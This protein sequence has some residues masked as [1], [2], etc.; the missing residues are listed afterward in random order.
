VEDLLARYTKPIRESRAV[1]LFLRRYPVYQALIQQGKCGIFL[2]M[3]LKS[4][5]FQEVVLKV[6]YHRGQVQPDGTDGCSLLRRELAFYRELDARN[7][8]SLAPRLVDALD[9]PRK[10]ILVLEY[11][12]GKNLLLRKLQGQLTVEHVERC[13]AIMDSL[14]ACGAYLGDAKLA[15]FMMTNDGD[16]RVLD[17]EAAGIF[18][19]ES[20]AFRTFFVNPEP[21]NPYLA[22]RAHFLASVLDSYEEGHFRWED[23]C[24][25]LGAWIRTKPKSAV[26]AWAVGKLREV[27]TSCAITL[28]TARHGNTNG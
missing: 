12:S 2:G 21:A 6:G 15:N 10:V 14:H 26:C 9:V 3:N 25:D 23:R 19:D 16:L 5:T 4:K 18:G 22:D 1:R 17:F 24:I 11:L 13:W 28:S 27:L 8:K 7:L 20:P